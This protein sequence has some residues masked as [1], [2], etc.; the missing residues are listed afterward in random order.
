VTAVPELHLADPGHCQRNHAVH[1]REDG[2]CHIKA[3][4]RQ[5]RVAD[6]E[7]RLAASRPLLPDRRILVADKKLEALQNSSYTCSALRD[8][9]V[10]AKSEARTIIET[11]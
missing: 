7:D 3:L 11:Y 2:D 8:F 10:R 1:C 5:R 4:Q 9:A 6:E